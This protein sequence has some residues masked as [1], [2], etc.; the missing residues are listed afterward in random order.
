MDIMAKH[1]CFGTIEYHKDN[2]SVI[3]G[4]ILQKVN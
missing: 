3:D 1:Q 2:F 4:L